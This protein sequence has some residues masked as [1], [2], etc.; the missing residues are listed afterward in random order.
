MA[1]V[2]KIK[3]RNNKNKSVSRGCSVKSRKS[4]DCKVKGV[5]KNEKN[6]EGNAEAKKKF[7]SPEIAKLESSYCF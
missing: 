6:G 5:K 4:R 7:L 2:N 3:V 1:T